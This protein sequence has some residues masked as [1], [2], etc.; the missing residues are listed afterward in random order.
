MPPNRINVL[1][2]N[3][4]QIN[5]DL[6]LTRHPFPDLT[7]TLRPQQDLTLTRVPQYENHQTL[8]QRPDLTQTR[9]P[10]QLVGNDLTISKAPRASREVELFHKQGPPQHSQTS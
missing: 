4:P 2:V 7:H 5:Q 1:P 10:I 9:L 8:I 3:Q 6:T